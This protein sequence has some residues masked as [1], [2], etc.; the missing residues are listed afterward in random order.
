M[1]CSAVKC[2]CRAMKKRKAGTY[3][4]VFCRVQCAGTVFLTADIDSASMLTELIYII[5]SVSE[6]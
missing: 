4:G 6:S 1:F 3:F 2:F 5:I